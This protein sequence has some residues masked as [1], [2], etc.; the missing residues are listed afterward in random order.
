MYLIN[1]HLYANT[2]NLPKILA[3][4]TAAAELRHPVQSLRTRCQVEK[5]ARSRKSAQT[6]GPEPWDQYAYG[7]SA[8]SHAVAACIR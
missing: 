2:A 6:C 3:E 4:D 1:Y 7:P 8:A 5:R